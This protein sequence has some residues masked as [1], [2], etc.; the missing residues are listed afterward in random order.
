M[1]FVWG[2]TIINDVTAREKQRDHKQFFLGKSADTF[3]PMGPVAVTKEDLPNVLEVIT[4]VNGKQRQRATTEDL[5]FSVP[6]LVATISLGQTIFP[7]DVIATGTPAGV[8]FGLS[9]PKWL[10]PGDEVEISVTGLG[11]LKNR[12]G[13]PKSRAPVTPATYAP[14]FN[15]KACVPQ[16]GPGVHR[17]QEALLQGCWSGCRKA[18][19]VYSWFRWYARLLQRPSRSSTVEASFAP[20]RS[21]RP[22]P[23]PS[24]SIFQSFNRLFRS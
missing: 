9:P 4:R 14:T 5:I 23:F 7:G 22:W 24:F 3:C 21:G 10:V 19:R 6:R 15:T 13:S 8:G 16:G 18:H 1:D 12:V 11:T 2:Y 20:L 17:W